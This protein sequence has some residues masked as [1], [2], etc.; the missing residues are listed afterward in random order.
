MWSGRDQLLVGRCIS[1]EPRHSV[2]APGTCVRGTTCASSDLGV[3]V[4]STKEKFKPLKDV[5]PK[6]H[7]VN[8][9]FFRFKNIGNCCVKIL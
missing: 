7:A 4:C 8:Y 6:W 1:P 5:I 2:A 3:S 9:Q